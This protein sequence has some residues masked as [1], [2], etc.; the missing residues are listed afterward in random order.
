MSEPKTRKRPAWG[1]PNAPP[2]I[3][4]PVPPPLSPNAFRQALGAEA[5]PLSPNA[6]RQALGQGPSH[7]SAPSPGTSYMPQAPRAPHSGM[8][9]A[10]AYN[11]PDPPKPEKKEEEKKPGELAPRVGE[12]KGDGK[13][14]ELSDREKWIKAA[15]DAAEAKAR[16]GGGRVIQPKGLETSQVT[17]KRQPGEPMIDELQE[18]LGLKE[19]PDRGVTRTLKP[20]SSTIGEGDDQEWIETPN[21]SPLEQ[22]SDKAAERGKLEEERR[23]AAEREAINNRMRGLEE[24]GRALDANLSTL[25]ERRT[26]IDTLRKAAEQSA[27][28]AKAFN[29]RTHEQVWQS[30]GAVGRMMGALAMTLG[31]YVQGL[32]RTGGRNPG[33][34]MVN[35]VIDDTVED[36]RD[37]AERGRR[38]SRDKQ[39][40]YERALA[41]YGDPE[42]AMLHS[43]LRKINSVQGMLDE[44]A[45]LKGLDAA[46]Q[47]RITGAQEAYR[48]AALN[49]AN[50]LQNR[51]NGIV[52]S[53]DVTMTKPKPIYVGGGGGGAPAV[54]ARQKAEADAAQ[55]Y[56]TIHGKPPTPNPTEAAAINK[57]EGNLKPFNDMLSN[58]KDSDKIPGAADFNI[59]SKGGRWIVD[60]VVGEGTAS[61]V[62]DSAEER[63]NRGIIGDFVAD[64]L[65][66]LS[67]SG[68]SNDE[69]EITRQRLLQARTKA[70]LV[71]AR[72]HAMAKI[73]ERRRLNEGGTP[74]T[75]SVQSSGEREAQ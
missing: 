59:I 8:A 56:D 52:L 70:D 51:V 35:K 38:T 39:S 48:L 19:R 46:T 41:L 72:N 32:G 63:N 25:S 14:A 58:Y 34:D 44:R 5:P 10:E 13:P 68:V 9:P 50:D 54:T 7:A 12:G 6:F 37:K 18:Y 42:A 40:D 45:K 22:L 67:G 3:P 33:A 20:G 60:K 2:D 15:G 28:E 29:P 36:E 21:R 55:Q 11:T 24:E 66:Q 64:T 57:A 4:P 30:K 73:A 53:E 27:N 74:A 23:I 31:G 75:P 43:K 17:Q 1:D 62:L 49:A 71:N 65:N 47:E 61:G 26:R 69:R 16:G